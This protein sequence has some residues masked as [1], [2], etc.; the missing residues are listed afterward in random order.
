MALPVVSV[1]QVDP[2]VE[3]QARWK[4]CAL[5][6]E[7]LKQPIV[8]CELGRL[9]NKEA[10]LMALLDKSNMPEVARHIRSLKDVT[11]L[12][13]TLNPSYK[14]SDKADT[15]NDTQTS[16]FAC[17]VTALEMSG[18]YRFVYLRGCGCVISEKALKEVPSLTC[19]KCGAGFSGEH[20]V[21]LN[22][23]EEEEKG[24]REEMEE[25][26]RQARLAKRKRKA[27]AATV[28]EASVPSEAT[29]SSS[30][31]SSGSDKE[32][33]PPPEK[34]QKP[35]PPSS[36][37]SASSTD[38]KSRAKQ[39]AKKSSSGGAAQARGTVTNGAQASR[40]GV[41][42]LSK[43]PAPTGEGGGDGERDKALEMAESRKV[44]QSLFTSNAAERPKEQKSNWVTF[45]PYH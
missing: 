3:L 2:A 19:H 35:L 39:A 16:E 15:Y 5:S 44:Y 34:K 4:Y 22:V 36:A 13:L 17:P 9:Y 28:E 30:G 32:S 38:T 29:G 7:E 11:V 21:R 45:F 23:S 25:R 1:H 31:T 6:G 24:A 8:A 43:P 26:R 33:P 41:S 14:P 20:V 27:V 42:K 12:Q 18:R 40:P 10:V 37:A